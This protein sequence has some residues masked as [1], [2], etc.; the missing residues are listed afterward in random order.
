MTSINYFLIAVKGTNSILM[1]IQFISPKS[2]V[3]TNCD[4]CDL[5][6]YGRHVKMQDYLDS[7]FDGLF[8]EIKW[9]LNGFM[10][11]NRLCLNLKY[12][13]HLLTIARVHLRLCSYYF[14]LTHMWQ[15]KRKRICTFDG[16]STYYGDILLSNFLK[17]FMPRW[18]FV[19]TRL[20]SRSSKQQL[21]QQ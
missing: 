5:W 16:K 1:E 11:I 18:G 15:R 19:R 7:I 13:R 2:L 17:C 20:S 9:F 10:I 14:V 8:F 12:S 6:F 3:N 4:F 21:Q